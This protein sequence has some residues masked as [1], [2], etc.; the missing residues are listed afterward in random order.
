[1]N[2]ADIYQLPVDDMDIDF[3]VLGEDLPEGEAFSSVTKRQFSEQSEQVKSSSSTAVALMRRKRR[4]A[5]ALPNDVT[6]ELRNVDLSDWNTDYLQ[7]MKKAALPK[8]K[9]AAIQRAKKNAEHYVWG[10]LG[11]IGKQFFAL[12]GPSPFDM[13]T[14]NKLFE[15][16]T[17]VSR[18]KVKGT[19]HD[20]DSGIDDETQEQSRRIRQKTGDP[21][22][23]MG[24]GPDEGFSM[25][26]GDDDEVELP[27]E[28]ETALDDQHIFSAMPWNISA[29]IRGSSV[30][31][32]S[33]L[34]SLEQG[35][36]G[37][38]LTSASPLHGRGQPGGLEALQSLES[39]G[40]YGLGGDDYGPPEPSS[41]DPEL[42]AH[43]QTS[44][45][46]RDALAA[47]GENF[48]VFVAE[49]IVEKCSRAQAAIDRM[50]DPLQA[51]AAADL[52]EITF[53]Q[54]LPPAENTKI[55]ASQ[56]LMQVLGLGMKGMLDIQQPEH[57][58][59]INLRLTQQA[60]AWRVVEISDQEESE[61]DNDV[62]DME[63]EASREDILEVQEE[64]TAGREGHFQDR[65]AAGH[66]AVQDNDHD[67]LYAD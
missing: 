66:A 28:A 15:L 63:L 36:R 33:G 18:E 10:S 32:R 37:S 8:T 24:R 26:G 2:A 35:K 56:G 58:G 1:M 7:N 51:E 64:E 25:P 31:P 59:E 55:V 44:I 11:G 60:K 29:S 54:L 43:T 22:K 30:V 14:G 45:R 16:I 19:K 23:E 41:D 67:S 17:G 13:F 5:R 38:R 65:I 48:L 42:A 53:E 12:P 40:D 47:E 4:T 34:G 46:I 3:P 50:A 62:S 57:L 9:A 39:E 6:I 21:D 49:A 61:D 20:R 27:R 52:D